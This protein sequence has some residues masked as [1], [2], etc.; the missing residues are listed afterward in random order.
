MHTPAHIHP[1][2]RVKAIM[3]A[4]ARAHTLTRGENINGTLRHTHTHWGREEEIIVGAGAR[5]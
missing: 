2:T 4:D 5:C 1:L 3:D